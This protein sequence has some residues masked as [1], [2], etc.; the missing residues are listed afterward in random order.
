[1]RATSLRQ[2]H[3]AARCKIPA[4]QRLAIDHTERFRQILNS[5]HS[6]FEAPEPVRRGFLIT[7]P[8]DSPD[9]AYTKN[10]YQ[11]L[12]WTGKLG[13][14]SIVSERGPRRPR[15]TWRGGRLRSIHLLV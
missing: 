14:F 12:S 10:L 11:V 3:K 5:C 1:M 2:F 6:I 7:V 9:T 15:L 8:M 13:R 4:T